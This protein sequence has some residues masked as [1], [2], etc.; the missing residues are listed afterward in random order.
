MKHTYCKV[1]CKHQGIEKPMEYGWMLKLASLEELL[2]YNM[3]DTSMRTAFQNAMKSK[4]LD[5]LGGHCSNKLAEILSGLALMTGR[6]LVETMGA[7]KRDVFKARSRVIQSTGCIYVN[8]V[9]GFFANGKNVREIKRIRYEGDP[10]NGFL[11]IQSN[12]DIVGMKARYMQWVDGRH[13]YAKMGNVDVKVD[14]CM[15]W[16]T[17]GEAVKAV[18]RFKE[19]LL[20]DKGAAK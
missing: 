14:G 10:H 9:G 15:K 18:K 2:D 8:A 1:T 17:K 12:A 5:R 11:E 20:S 7:L 13:W 4:P 19:N 6:P 3:T 16:D